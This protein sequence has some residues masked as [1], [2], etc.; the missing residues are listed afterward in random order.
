MRTESFGGRVRAR[1]LGVEQTG[2][3]YPS[4]AD[5]AKMRTTADP[6]PL[7]A[8]T[9]HSRR[10][11]SLCP[12][13]S[14]GTGV[15]THP[16]QKPPQAAVAKASD[17]EAVPKVPSFTITAQATSPPDFPRGTAKDPP[18]MPRTSALRSG[19]GT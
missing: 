9:T 15:Y 11:R 7:R 14:A 1:T 17:A 13:S 19:A 4:S 12:R 16:A 5:D 8:L 6:D 3:Y 2:V 18:F 10:T